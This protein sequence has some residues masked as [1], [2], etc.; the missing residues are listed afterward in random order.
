MKNRG[1]RGGPGRE[2]WLVTDGSVRNTGVLAF[3][4]AEVL[5]GHYRDELLRREALGRRGDDAKRRV[6][7][8]TANELP[9]VVPIAVDAALDDLPGAWVVQV[10]ERSGRMRGCTFSLSKRPSRPV[11]HQHTSYDAHFTGYG[12]S[13]QDAYYAARRARDEWQGRMTPRA[14]EEYGETP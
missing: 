12:I 4:T 14:W 6:S 2:A 9:K 10:D 3:F 7:L 8:F 13:P 5:A 11:E 1:D